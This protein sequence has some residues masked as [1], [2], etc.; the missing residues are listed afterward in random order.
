MKRST[1]AGITFVLVLI[2]IVYAIAQLNEMHHWFNGV[3]QQKYYVLCLI[4]YIAFVVSSFCYFMF[5]V[6]ELQYKRSIHI[7][8]G[9]IYGEKHFNLLYSY[10]FLAFAAVCFYVD[11]WHYF[12]MSVGA[13]VLWNWVRTKQ[14]SF[15]D[16]YQLER[17]KEE[18]KKKTTVVLDD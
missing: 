10:H 11:S 2:E 13:W 15:A 14:N 17:K 1:F 16:E 5:S 3:L 18:A 4:L 12:F 9:E 7:H 6:P 8:F